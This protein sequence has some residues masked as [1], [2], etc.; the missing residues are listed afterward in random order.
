[1]RPRRDRGLKEETSRNL[2]IVQKNTTEMEKTHNVGTRA[3]TNKQTKNTCPDVENIYSDC[4]SNYDPQ[5][6]DTASDK[7]YLLG[8]E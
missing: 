5:G 1:M 7:V 8:P 2:K 3:K 6:S 4:V